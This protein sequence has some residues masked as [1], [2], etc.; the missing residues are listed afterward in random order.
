LSHCRFPLFFDDFAGVTTVPIQLCDV[1]P[2]LKAGQFF[3]LPDDFLFHVVQRFFSSSGYGI[4]NGSDRDR[5]LSTTGIPLLLPQLAITMSAA[6]TYLR[7]RF[8]AS[9]VS[10]NRFSS[11][12]ENTTL[13]DR[14]SFVSSENFR[15][16][17]SD[18]LAI[19]NHL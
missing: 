16:I 4:S 3:F 9:R 17:G 18:V 10:T 6:G 2:H 15:K 19:E 12:R 7:K 5:A 1:E 11:W 14:K 8:F 13:A